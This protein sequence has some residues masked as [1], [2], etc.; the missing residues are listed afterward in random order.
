MCLRFVAAVA[1]VLI[2]VSFSPLSAQTYQCTVSASGSAANIIPPAWRIE[3]RGDRAAIAHSWFGQ[4]NTVE[5][6]VRGSSTRK[7]MGFVINNVQGFGADLANLAFSVSHDLT[8][9]ALLIRIEPRGFDN[10]FSGRGQCSLL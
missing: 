1:I 10:S 3:Y 2:F 5:T 6:S 8:T 4:P 7:R 9:G